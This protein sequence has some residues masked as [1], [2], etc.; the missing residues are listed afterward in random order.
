[1]VAS[2]S[3]APPPSC[4]AVGSASSSAASFCLDGIKK[5]FGSINVSMGELIVNLEYNIVGSTVQHTHTML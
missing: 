5:T 1:M 2:T 3:A 4:S